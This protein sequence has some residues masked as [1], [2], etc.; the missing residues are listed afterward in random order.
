MKMGKMPQYNLLNYK[1]RLFTKQKDLCS[2]CYKQ[3]GNNEEVHF[4]YIQLIS[5]KDSK[6]N[7]NNMT[8]VYSF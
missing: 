1:K 7:I 4:H 2:L 8:L 3:I 5:K 6:R